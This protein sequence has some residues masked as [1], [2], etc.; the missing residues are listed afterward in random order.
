MQEEIKQ[1]LESEKSRLRAEA[2]TVWQMA[3]VAFWTWLS[4]VAVRSQQRLSEKLDA[5][6]AVKDGH[7]E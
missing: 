2:R 3:Q 1:F 6:N 5:G 7:H 4:G